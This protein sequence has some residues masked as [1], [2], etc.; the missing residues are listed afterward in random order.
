MLLQ[1]NPSAHLRRRVF[2]DKRPY[3]RTVTRNGCCRE[4][5]YLKKSLVDITHESLYLLCADKQTH[6]RERHSSLRCCKM[7]HLPRGKASSW[8]SLYRSLDS[9]PCDIINVSGLLPHTSYP[10]M[11]ATTSLRGS[12]DDKTR[13]ARSKS[14]GQGGRGV[15]S[16]KSGEILSP[17]TPMWLIYSHIGISTLEKLKIL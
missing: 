7:Q 12:L 6:G 13:K 8:M 2:P 15:H 5:L 14:Q 17:G 1:T 3:H 10:R 11:K 9:E 16:A 4:S